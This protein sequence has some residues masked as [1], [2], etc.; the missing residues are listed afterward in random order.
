MTTLKF[1]NLPQ[2]ATYAEITKKIKSTGLD[3]D[4]ISVDTA[5]NAIVF[6]GS[7]SHGKPCGTGLSV[8]SVAHE[9]IATFEGKIALK[10]WLS[11]QAAST[12]TTWKPVKEIT[13]YEYIE[14]EGTLFP[15]HYYPHRAPDGSSTDTRTPAE[16]E[17]GG[18]VI[19]TAS[20]Y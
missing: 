13:N 12:R 20:R 9:L 6:D 18:F 16:I 5:D 11:T 3:A 4:Q 15:A 2:N 19:F 17:T 14:V 10:G 8:D 7:S 1:T